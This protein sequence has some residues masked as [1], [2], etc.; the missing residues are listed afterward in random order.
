M[1]SVENNDT[2]T[3]FSFYLCKCD[4]KNG[5]VHFIHHLRYIFFSSEM[6][7]CLRDLPHNKCVVKHTLMVTFVFYHHFIPFRIPIISHCAIHFQMISVHIFSFYHISF[8]FRLKIL[9]TWQTDT[10]YHLLWQ[11]AL[12]FHHSI[13]F[14]GDLVNWINNESHWF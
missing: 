14:S 5:L 7:T 10:N 1:H 8:S 6:W 13:R 4:S 9:D 11:R 2:S 12:F 3:F